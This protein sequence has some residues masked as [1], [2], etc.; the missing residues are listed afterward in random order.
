MAF[1][2]GRVDKLQDQLD[3]MAH[4]WMLDRVME[5]YQVEDATD[6]TELQAKEIV[7]YAQS[8]DCDPYVGMALRS[9]VGEY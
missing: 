6:L 2:P 3:A 4:D 5:F 7:D 8:D 1:D 9:I